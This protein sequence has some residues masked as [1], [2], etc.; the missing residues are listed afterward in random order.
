MNSKPYSRRVVCL[1]RDQTFA[2][3]LS[4]RLYVRVGTSKFFWDQE[5]FAFCESSS[6]NSSGWVPTSSTEV[7]FQE[8][9][10]RYRTLALHLCQN[11]YQP[12]VYGH[13]EGRRV[14]ER[15]ASSTAAH[16]VRTGGRCRHAQGRG[17][18]GSSSPL[19]LFWRENS[20]I[21]KPRK[22]GKIDRPRTENHCHFRHPLFRST[23]PPAGLGNFPPSCATQSPIMAT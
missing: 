17:S 11:E 23:L 5:F 16:P 8:T 3:R 2:T 10:A 22:R 21:R 19:F 9:S 15:A 20:K 18:G 12:Q 14:R 13:V 1:A 7:S 6:H 4:N